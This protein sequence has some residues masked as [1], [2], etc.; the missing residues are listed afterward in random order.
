MIRFLFAYNRGG[1]RPDMTL[2]LN[3]ARVFPFWE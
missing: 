2:R 3:G 1:P